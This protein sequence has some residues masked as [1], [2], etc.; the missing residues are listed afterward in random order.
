MA[1]PE[2]VRYT[3]QEAAALAGVRLRRIQNALT[4][5]RLGRAFGTRGGRRGIDLPAVLTF[6]VVDRLGT[7]RI[8]PATLY[9]T[10]RKVGVPHGPLAVTEAVTLD[11]SALLVTV[12]RNL[13]LYEKAR[14]RIVSDK[15]VMGGLPVVKGTRLPATTLHARVKGGDTIESILEDYPYLDR[16][17]IEAAVLFVDANPARGRPRRR[18][19][20][21]RA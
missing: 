16:E 17:T 7:V 11:A 2:A 4:D 8:E 14:E 19:A 10:F 6:A 15:T 3:P 13:A 1:R 12:V 20:S 5:R 21:S 9:R 18:P